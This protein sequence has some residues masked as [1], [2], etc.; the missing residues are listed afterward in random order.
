M[1]ALG[2]AGTTAFE[3]L[4]SGSPA[5]ASNYEYI[6][7]SAARSIISPPPDLTGGTFSNH[8][9][10]GSTA[11]GVDYSGNGTTYGSAI[12]AVKPG[13]VSFVK[14]DNSGTYGRQV[15]VDHGDGSVTKY[16]HLKSTGVSVNA[17]VTQGA[18]IGQ[19]G[20]SANGND[21]TYGAHLHICLM[22]DGSY[23]DFAL[24]V[25]NTLATDPES[26]DM[27]YQVV[28]RAGSASTNGVIPSGAKLTRSP[29]GVFR[30]LTPE[31]VNVITYFEGLSTPIPVVRHYIDWTGQKIWEE[32][33]RTGLTHW[34]GTTSAP[35]YSGK[36]WLAGVADYPKYKL[37]V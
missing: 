37:G 36:I 2:F 6:Y 8:V 26:D 14:S 4:S 24:C 31:E 23:K 34:D 33:N 20:G 30:L 10:H 21:N 29:D 12:V 17:T 35:Q 1:M 11:P 27:L 28:F 22:I 18:Q 9:A 16:M 19:M 13:T 15:H 3:V 25:E 32:A 5:L 7:P